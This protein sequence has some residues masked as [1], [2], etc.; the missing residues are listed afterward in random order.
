MAVNCSD[1]FELVE[2]ETNKLR[3]VFNVK[4]KSQQT[5]YN[6]IQNFPSYACRH[7][8]AQTFKEKSLHRLKIVLPEPNALP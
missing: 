1:L 6:L 4:Q 8:I 3:R 5:R 2:G 7:V